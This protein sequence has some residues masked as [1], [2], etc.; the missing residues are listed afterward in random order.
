MRKHT[1]YT[2]LRRIMHLHNEGVSTVEISK[3]VC[4][5][6]GEVQKVIDIRTAKPTAKTVKKKIKAEEPLTDR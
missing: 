1:T 4:I 2:D 6:M 5:D 3:E